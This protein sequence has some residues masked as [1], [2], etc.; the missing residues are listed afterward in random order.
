MQVKTRCLDQYVYFIISGLFHKWQWHVE[1]FL[2]GGS[3]EE[4]ADNPDLKDYI[5]ANCLDVEP[6]VAN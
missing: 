1:T 4:I 5:S 2:R 6:I 3:R